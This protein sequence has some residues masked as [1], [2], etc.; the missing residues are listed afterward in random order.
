M[1][2]FLTKM[3]VHARTWECSNVKPQY[4]LVKNNNEKEKQEKILQID[5][6][7]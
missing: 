7:Q 2:L 5:I 1:L 4:V 6:L 3:S